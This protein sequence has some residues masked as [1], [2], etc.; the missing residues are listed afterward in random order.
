MLSNYIKISGRN[1]LTNK[2]FSFINILVM[3]ISVANVFL[4]CYRT[5]ND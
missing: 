3:S 2:V 4:T 1:L 5:N